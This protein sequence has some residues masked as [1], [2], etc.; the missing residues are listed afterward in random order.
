MELGFALVAALLFLAW[1]TGRRWLLWPAFL[2]SLGLGSG[3]SLASHQSDDRGWLPSFADWVH[4]S[5]ATLWIGGLLSLGLVV[6]R[7][8]GLRKTAFWRFSEIAG[9]LV[10]LVVAAGTY[11]TYKRFPAL[12]DL[13]SVGYGQLLLVKLSLVCVALLWGGFHHFVVRPR[14]GRPEVPGGPVVAGRRGAVA[15]AILLLAAVLVDSKPP[16]KPAPAPTQALTARR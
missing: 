1:L 4:L 11:M 9:P 12:H 6:W 16:A 8:R 7:D 3:L 2:L 13:W 5:A 15:V 10:A 14:L